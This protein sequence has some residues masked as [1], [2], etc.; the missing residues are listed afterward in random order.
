MFAE[1]GN[2][3]AR[4][5]NLA[6]SFGRIDAGNNIKQCRFSSAVTTDNG[7]K[8]LGANIQPDII[9]RHNLI[10]SAP[11]EYLAYLPDL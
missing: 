2:I 6:S 4:N 11:G 5:D 8:V 7:H 9:Q 10:D 1:V 3:L